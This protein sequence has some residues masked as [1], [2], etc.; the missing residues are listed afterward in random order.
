MCS[1]LS[2]SQF[3]PGRG[4]FLLTDSVLA[5]CQGAE[6]VTVL[7][8]LLPLG[9]PGSCVGQECQLLVLALHLCLVALRGCSEGH[10]RIIWA[11]APF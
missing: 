9:C 4:G 7:S 11:L 5:A 1:C 10:V 2:P 3:N 6:V 8:R